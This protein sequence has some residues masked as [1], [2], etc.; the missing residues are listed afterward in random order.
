VS[1][2][3]LALKPESY[4]KSLNDGVY[5]VDTNRRI[6]DWGPSA[7]RITGRRASDIM[8]KRCSDDV[9]SHVDK[10]GRR[11]C[12]REHCPLHRAMVTEMRLTRKRPTGSMCR[13]MFRS[14]SSGRYQ[15]IRLKYVR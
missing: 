2:M 10:E 11:L 12:G 7:E 8:G 4:L 15:S 5:A 14:N 9:L 13:P 1:E 6:I 3:D